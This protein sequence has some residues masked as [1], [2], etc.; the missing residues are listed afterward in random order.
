MGWILID[1]DLYNNINIICWC[2]IAFT[3][4]CV[5]CV[6]S[7]VLFS[8]SPFFWGSSLLHTH[9]TIPY[10]WMK[11]LTCAHV[12]EAHDPFHRFVV[13][14]TGPY[15]YKKCRSSP[16]REGQ[17]KSRVKSWYRSSCCNTRYKYKWWLIPVGTSNSYMYI[18]W[19]ILLKTRLLLSS[20][21]VHNLLHTASEWSMG[22]SR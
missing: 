19:R 21:P 17:T 2:L 1:N 16:T 14:E 20:T 18:L 4:I 5:Y 15:K 3:F 9:S 8:P 7:F 12:C 11:N 13:H 6:V 10:T 22:S